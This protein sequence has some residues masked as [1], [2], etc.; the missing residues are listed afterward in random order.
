MSSSIMLC[1]VLLFCHCFCQN[2]FFALCQYEHFTLEQ[3]FNP[4]WGNNEI[5]RAWPRYFGTEPD[6][7]TPNACPV[8]M[9]CMRDADTTARF[10]WPVY[11][12]IESTVRTSH[13][14]RT[15]TINSYIDLSLQGSLHQINFANWFYQLPGRKP[16]FDRSHNSSEH[17]CSRVTST[18]H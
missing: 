13:R 7:C 5:W 15:M 6:I 9:T 18:K 14:H 3:C 4:N 8:W 16:L 2:Q 11:G 12:S 1:L 17:C 10:T